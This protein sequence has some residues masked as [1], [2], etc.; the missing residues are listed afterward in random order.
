ML[1]LS[2]Q[3]QLWGESSSIRTYSG[4]A[5]DPFPF[6]TPHL[7]CHIPFY[8]KIK[9]L[10]SR[11]LLV[12]LSYVYSVIIIS[13]HAEKEPKFRSQIIQFDGLLHLI[14][15]CCRRGQS[16]IY[17]NATV[18]IVKLV[19]CGPQTAGVHDACPLSRL[20]SIYTQGRDLALLICPT[21]T[22]F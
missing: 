11:C 18:A 4:D 14:C 5:F 17:F 12:F 21:R 1:S 16:C 13:R 9:Y 6:V 22:V 8:S 2:R 3:R 20:A 15:M 7:N 10:I 19:P